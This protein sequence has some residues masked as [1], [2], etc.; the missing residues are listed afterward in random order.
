MGTATEAARGVT[1]GILIMWLSLSAC[2]SEGIRA[3]G[4]PLDS[5][6]PEYAAA[7]CA[8]LMACCDAPVADTSAADASVVVDAG[9]AGNGGGEDCETRI[10]AMIARSFEEA[11]VYHG[12]VAGDCLEDRLAQSACGRFDPSGTCNAVIDRPLLDAAELDSRGIPD[13]LCAP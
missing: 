2:S 12:D 10:E 13:G 1:A 6:G 8:E 9:G 5:F 3:G 7:A 11:T 4:V